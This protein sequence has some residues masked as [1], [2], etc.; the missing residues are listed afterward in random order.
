VFDAYDEDRGVDKMRVRWLPI[1]LVVGAFM[2]LSGFGWPLEARDS[3]EVL[4]DK[5]KTSYV[6]GSD[7]QAVR[8]EERDKER[9]WQMLQNGNF[10]IDGRN[11]G[12]VPQT[13]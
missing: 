1:L 2:V 4:K 8:E 5:D 10:L 9:A 3:M 11:R 6:I 7:E 13:K 12:R